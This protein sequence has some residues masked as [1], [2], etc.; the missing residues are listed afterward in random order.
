MRAQREVKA[1]GDSKR[2]AFY[3]KGADDMKRESI[4]KQ[5]AIFL[6]GENTLTICPV[7]GDRIRLSSRDEIEDF[8]CQM[9]AFCHDMRRVHAMKHALENDT[10]FD[11]P[12][13]CAEYSDHKNHTGRVMKIIPPDSGVLTFRNREGVEDFI[14]DLRHQSDSILCQ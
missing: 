3:V 5:Y 2:G 8:I 9:K 6:G 13:F 14:A 12:V 4:K 7:D 11:C 1:Y 10:E